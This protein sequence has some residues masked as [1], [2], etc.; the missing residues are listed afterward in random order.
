MVRR[1]QDLQSLQL[2]FEEEVTRKRRVNLEALRNSG[3]AGDLSTIRG[4]RGRVAEDWNFAHKHVDSP[5]YIRF[6]KT[7][8]SSGRSVKGHA[9]PGSDP[10]SLAAQAREDYDAVRNLDNW[11]QDTEAQEVS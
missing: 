4:T 8:V 7:V 6:E 2:T 1:K 5:A 11:G 3:R 9:S 10:H